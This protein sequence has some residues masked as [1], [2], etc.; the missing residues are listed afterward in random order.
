MRYPIQRKNRFKII[1]FGETKICLKRMVLSTFLKHAIS[2][3]FLFQ[4]IGYDAV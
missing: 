1:Q 2:N 3:F 4:W